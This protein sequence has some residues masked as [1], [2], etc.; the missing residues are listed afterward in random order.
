MSPTKNFFSFFFFKE[1][2]KKK[3]LIVFLSF[4]QKDE[5]NDAN[6]HTTT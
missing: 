6:V 4:S 1:K 2:T 3:P 5:K